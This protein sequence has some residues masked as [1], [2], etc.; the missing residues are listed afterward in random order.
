MLKMKRQLKVLSGIKHAMLLLLKR[1]ENLEFIE[2]VL[3]KALQFLKVQKN[4]I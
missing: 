3:V 1:M 4:L 2:L